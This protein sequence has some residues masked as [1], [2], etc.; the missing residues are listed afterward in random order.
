MS[1]CLAR[2]LRLIVVCQADSRIRSYLQTTTNFYLFQHSMA[3]VRRSG[4]NTTRP[5]CYNDDA[6][7]CT[8]LALPIAT[9]ALYISELPYKDVNMKRTQ[10]KRMFEEAKALRSRHADIEFLDA[11]IILGDDSIATAAE[12]LENKRVIETVTRIAGA[13]QDDPNPDPYPDPCPDFSPDFDPDPNP[14][15]I[16]RFTGG[17]RDGP[18]G[19][20]P[21]AKTLHVTIESLTKEK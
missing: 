4:R 2:S 14:D 1:M 5:V 9:G 16:P 18:G 19:A 12:M 3:R 13:L 7:W 10:P 21:H 15:L 8:Q 17:R 20:A 6:W 11:R